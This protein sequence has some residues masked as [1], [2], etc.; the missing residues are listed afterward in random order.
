MFDI[1]QSR[2]CQSL[3]EKKQLI[4]VMHLDEQQML[5]ISQI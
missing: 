2:W 1:G 5:L 3:C 4:I